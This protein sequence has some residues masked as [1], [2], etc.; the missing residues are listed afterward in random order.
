MTSHRTLVLVLVFSTAT[1]AVAADSPEEH[2]AWRRPQRPSVPPVAH[3]PGSSEIRN[4]IDAFI[5]DR[6]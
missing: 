6:L 1:V 3:A 4:P 5:V 2:W